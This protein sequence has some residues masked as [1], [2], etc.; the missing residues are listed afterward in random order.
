MVFV[1]W[2]RIS[3]SID[4]DAR[5]LSTS[6]DV[7]ISI[8]LIGIA[9]DAVDTTICFWQSDKSFCILNLHCDAGLHIASFKMTSKFLMMNWE[10]SI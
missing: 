10:R 2:M 5:C 7:K 1:N 4:G 8:I 9:I 6:K 3:L